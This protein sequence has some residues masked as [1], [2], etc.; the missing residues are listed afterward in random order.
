MM[1]LKE[2]TVLARLLTFAGLD[3]HVLATVIFRG[4]GIVAGA[5][6]T[7]LLP[8]FLSPTEQGFYYT[9]GGVLALQVFFELGL[10]HVLT[11]LAG[12]SAAHLRRGQGGRL[13]GDLRWRRAVA[14]LLALSQKWNA[15]MATLFAIALLTGGV[16][17]FDRRG[18]LPVQDWIG[19]WITLISAAAINL[20]LSARLAI[21]EGIGE[22]ADVAKLRLR[23]SM[24]GYL[25]LWALLLSG[26]G[27]SAV[28]AVPLT[29]AI[30]TAWW[31]WHHPNLRVLCAEVAQEP[32]VGTEE[33]EWRR[34]IF[35]L[36]WK[37]ALS[38]A[39]GYFIFSFLTPVV[40][41]LQGPVAAGRLGLALTIFSA[42][43]TVGISWIAA[44]IPTFAAHIARHER[45]ALNTLFDHQLRRSVGATLVCSLAVTAG[46]FVAGNFAPTILERL[47]PLSIL[48]M[49]AI[50]TVAN[51]V[52]FAMAAYM[53]AHKEEP[54]LL[55]SM[56]TAA[57]IG[58]G[59]FA[60]AHHSLQ[61][62]VAAYSAATLFVSLP[63]C[64][65]LYAKY[66]SRT[67]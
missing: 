54:L 35:P 12:H 63:W 49:L 32:R 62:T 21:C 26:Q 65:L 9:F 52:V 14:S 27:L 41:A 29:S 24:V 46:A 13:E 1:A 28:I 43:S 22:V 10:N 50:V 6:T 59:V 2:P 47:P 40:F 3:I 5:A 37:I 34:D 31:L 67:S 60:G 58:V 16:Y 53:R 56:V 18:T 57:L 23:Q 8:L 11:Q 45:S 33:F 17:F 51:A 4:W 30:S 39:S 38:W 48:L 61:A 66:R 36:Q 42:V 64:A 44:K 55:Q 25:L 20:A 15:I 19:P 7:I